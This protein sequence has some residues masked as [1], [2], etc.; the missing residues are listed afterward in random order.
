MFHSQHWWWCLAWWCLRWSGPE[1]RA[2]A[3]TPRPCWCHTQTQSN[4][5]LWLFHPLQ[6][7]NAKF[8]HRW[9]IY[10]EA[11]WKSGSGHIQ[12]IVISTYHLIKW[13]HDVMK[14][15]LAWLKVISSFPS[16]RMW[17]H[18]KNVLVY[19]WT[20]LCVFETSLQCAAKPSKYNAIS[21]QFRAATTLM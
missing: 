1:G 15:W 11:Q 16:W 8:E 4:P 2:L 9:G 19:L 3:E 18:H 20:K 6:I 13:L 10:W 7:C 5:C 21:S 14:V 12:N 17:Y